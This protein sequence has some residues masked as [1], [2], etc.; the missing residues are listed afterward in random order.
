MQFDIYTCCLCPPSK[1][2]DFK[3][4]IV[5]YKIKT[6]GATAMTK[7][8]NVQSI[9]RALDIIEVL[10]DYQDGLGVTEIAARIGLNK[11]TVHR[12]LSTLM[13][14]GYV[15][16]TDKGAYRLGINLIEVVSCYINNLELQDLLISLKIVMSSSRL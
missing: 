14:R 4:R 9:E 2:L 16:K 11:S 3:V 13:A 5:Y 15:S 12:I 7:D 8:N 6:K 10:A 1:I